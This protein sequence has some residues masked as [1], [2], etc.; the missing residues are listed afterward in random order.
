MDDTETELLKA[1]A[2]AMGSAGLWKPVAESTQARRPHAAKQTNGTKPKP[3]V[4]LSGG[5]GDTDFIYA[6]GFD[7]ETA[8]Y[9]RFDEMDDVIYTSPLE[10]DRARAQARAS[11]VLLD[12]NAYANDAWAT[13]AAKKVLERGFAQARVSP[14]LHAHFLEELR[15]AGL[16]PG[17]VRDP[18]LAQRR[19]K[20]SA[21]GARPLKAQHDGAGAWGEGVEP[22]T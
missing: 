1:V 8:A 20:A 19:R 2:Q 18:F 12:Q 13:L 11:R 14:R 5:H 17:V 9:L 4:L 21:E 6:T 10:I 3:I 15:A 22:P 7:V 16:A